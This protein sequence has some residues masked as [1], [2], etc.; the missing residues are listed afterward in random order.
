MD[1]QGSYRN[2]NIET[3]KQRCGTETTNDMPKERAGE[4]CRMGMLY[5]ADDAFDD[6]L[7]TIVG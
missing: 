5:L 1:R 3:A 6:S 2:K 4:I 7:S